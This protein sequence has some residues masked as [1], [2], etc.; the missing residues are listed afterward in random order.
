MCLEVSIFEN[1]VRLMV[2]KT[3]QI[4][5]ETFHKS[6]EYEIKLV[7]LRKDHFDKL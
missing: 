5:S 6:T 3:L 1:H 2:R 7:E 4:S